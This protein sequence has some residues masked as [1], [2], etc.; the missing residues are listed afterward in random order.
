MIPGPQI[1]AQAVLVE[2]R[3]RVVSLG[4]RLLADAS[5]P[6]LVEETVTWPSGRGGSLDEAV[7]SL[8]SA[9][10]RVLGLQS[11]VLRASIVAGADGPVLI[12]LATGLAGGS[13]STHAVPLATGVDLLGAAVRLACGEAPSISAAPTGG[14][15]GVACRTLLPPSGLVVEIRGVADA[16][17]S[18][19]VVA[20]DVWIETGMRV[21]LATTRRHAAGMIVAVGPTAG[22]AR[23]R[24][25]AAAARIRLVTRAP[26]ARGVVPTA[27]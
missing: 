2:G 19:G 26:L 7:E 10:A 5:S 16:A 27:P 3:T 6:F 24:A 15:R 25:D 17:A 1:A 22:V 23:A 21:D 11:G 18:E 13:S 4:D 14:G 8:V 12:A 20:A 9:A